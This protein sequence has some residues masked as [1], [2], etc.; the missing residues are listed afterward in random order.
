MDDVTKIGQGTLP[1]SPSAAQEIRREAGFELRDID[2]Q[3]VIGVK[4]FRLSQY[5]DPHNFH[6]V[7]DL[8]LPSEGRDF[9]TVI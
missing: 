4:F 5:E 7:S 8:Y 9:L 3:P 1:M 6:L 2:A